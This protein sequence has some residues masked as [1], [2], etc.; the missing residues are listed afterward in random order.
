VAVTISGRLT[1]LPAVKGTTL[2]IKQPLQ[3]QPSEARMML[4]AIA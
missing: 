4:L 1:A 3:A 2:L